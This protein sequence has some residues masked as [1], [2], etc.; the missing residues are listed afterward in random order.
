M[1]LCKY[2]ACGREITAYF[3]LQNNVLIFETFGRVDILS[4]R[5]VAVRYGHKSDDP[6]KGRQLSNRQRLERFNPMAMEK[7]SPA[8][9]RT[10]G[11]D[12]IHH[13]ISQA[14]P[15]QTDELSALRV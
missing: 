13:N 1:R 12:P 14:H 3:C 8:P 7:S 11:N 2:R 10:E 6:I 4:A 5:A 15:S 9:S